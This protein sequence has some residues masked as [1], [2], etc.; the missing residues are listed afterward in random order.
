MPAIERLVADRL[1]FFVIHD[2]KTG[3]ILFTGRIVGPT[4]Q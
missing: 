2:G 4:Q 3:A 1:F